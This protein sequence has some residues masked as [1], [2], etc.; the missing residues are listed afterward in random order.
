MVHGCCADVS[1]LLQ[2]WVREDDPNCSFEHHFY[3]PP[4]VDI[5]TEEVDGPQLRVDYF[6][7]K[8][9]VREFVQ[10]EKEAELAAKD[11]AKRSKKNKGKGKQQEDVPSSMDQSDDMTAAPVASAEPA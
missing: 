1:R 8:Q 10:R 5:H 4:G 9:Q 7:T 6:D 2:G 3:V 11:A